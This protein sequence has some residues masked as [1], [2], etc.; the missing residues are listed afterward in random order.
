MIEF[1]D[2]WFEPYED[3]DEGE[4]DDH[5]GVRPAAM[6]PDGPARVAA[7]AGFFEAEGFSRTPPTRARYARVESRLHEFLDDVDVAPFIGTGPAALLVAERERERAG[8]FLRIFGFDELVCCLEGFLLDPWLPV[9][10]GERRTQISLAKRLLEHMRL[11]GWFDQMIVS[12]AYY[13]TK[14]AIE[15]ARREAVGRRPVPR[16]RVDGLRLVDP[17]S[18]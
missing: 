8:A 4:D 12:C 18:W 15:R 7:L 2:D 6:H 3:E 17:W 13:D 11:Q 9:H 14:N 5:V 10:A 16:A 1:H